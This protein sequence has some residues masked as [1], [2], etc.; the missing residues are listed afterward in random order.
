MRDNNAAPFRFGGRD[1]FDC[2]I[3]KGYYLMKIIL[4]FYQHF[5]TMFYFPLCKNLV[6]YIRWCTKEA[7]QIVEF[8]LIYFFFRFS[9]EE[10]PFWKFFLTLKMFLTSKLFL[11]N[12]PNSLTL[13]K[14]GNDKLLLSLCCLLCASR[15]FEKFWFWCCL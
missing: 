2:Q 7:F 10:F 6:K 14:W 12:F 11:I 13:V 8:S 15:I 3:Y 1:I 4:T 9:F 5:L